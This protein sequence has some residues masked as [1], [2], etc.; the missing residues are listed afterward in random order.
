MDEHRENRSS[1][2]EKALLGPKNT[3]CALSLNFCPLGRGAVKIRQLWK[4]GHLVIVQ[5]L[6]LYQPG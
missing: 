3:R 4:T 2:E 1:T 5:E 6:S